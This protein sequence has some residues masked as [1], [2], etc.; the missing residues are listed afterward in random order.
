MLPNLDPISY[1]ER[2]RGEGEESETYV[3]LDPNLK[4]LQ[5]ISY[6]EREIDR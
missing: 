5:G 6:L 2:E 3:R 4:R 1:L